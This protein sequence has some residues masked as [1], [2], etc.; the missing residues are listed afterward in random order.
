MVDAVV[1][2]HQPLPDKPADENDLAGLIQIPCMRESGRD[3]AKQVRPT[4]KAAGCV[5]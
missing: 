4:A 3:R 2:L 5:G 1:E